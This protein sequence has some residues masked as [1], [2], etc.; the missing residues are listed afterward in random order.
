MADEEN[1][2]RPQ[3]HSRTQGSA[4]SSRGNN[5]QSPVTTSTESKKLGSAGSSRPLKEQKP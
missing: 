3:T 1:T 4:P 2:S 5:P